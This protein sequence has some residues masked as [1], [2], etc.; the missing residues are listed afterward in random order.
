MIGDTL[1]DFHI[2]WVEWLG[3]R[4]GHGHVRTCVGT[5]EHVGRRTILIRR[6]RGGLVVKRMTMAIMDAGRLSARAVPDGYNELRRWWE[7]DEDA[8]LAMRARFAGAKVRRATEEAARAAQQAAWAA[9]AADSDE[10]PF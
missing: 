9:S 4:D 8:D 10:I 5:V 2:T 6:P 7:H 1:Q 3:G